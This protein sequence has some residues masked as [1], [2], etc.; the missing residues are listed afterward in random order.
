MSRTPTEITEN[1]KL[2]LSKIGSKEKPVYVDCRPNANSPQKMC[3]QIVDAKVKTEGGDRI[4]G[5]QIWQGQ[6]LVEAEFHAVWKTPSNQLLDI[7][8]KP[9][10]VERILFVADPRAKYENKQINN[11]RMNIMGNPLV[12]EFI[13][14]HDAVFRIKNQGNRASQYGLAYLF[15]FTINECIALRKLNQA[16]HMLQTMAQNGYTRN[17]PCICGSGEKYEVCHGNV[18][19]KLLNDF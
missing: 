17:S 12:D 16:K 15:S 4:L 6:L 10:P 3:F 13:S 14:V 9:F 7:T 5:W 11:I 8:P 18:I 2:L 1:I 19:G